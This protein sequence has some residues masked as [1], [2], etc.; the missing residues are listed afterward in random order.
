MFVEIERL[1]AVAVA[2]AVAMAVQL[3]SFEEVS[4]TCSFAWLLALA[5][6]YP[7][8]LGVSA[9]LTAGYYCSYLEY[10]LSSLHRYFGLPYCDY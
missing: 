3:I 10:D 7:F 4:T 9:S 5:P 8:Y 6:F 1:V 2:V